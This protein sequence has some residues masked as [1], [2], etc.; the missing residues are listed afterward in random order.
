MTIGNAQ[1]LCLFVGKKLQVLKQLFTNKHFS[2]KLNTVGPTI[3]EHIVF[4]SNLFSQ[5]TILKAPLKTNYFRTYYKATKQ[6]RFFCILKTVFEKI[7]SL[8]SMFISSPF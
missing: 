5:Y 2:S 6:T 4:A 3:V 7:T 1:I 8:L